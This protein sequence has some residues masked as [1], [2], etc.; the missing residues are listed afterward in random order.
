V[1]YLT[2]RCI[3]PASDLKI[4]DWLRDTVSIVPIAFPIIVDTGTLT[5]LLYIRA[6]FHDVEN[7]IVAIL[8][9]LVFVYLVLRYVHWIEKI[10]G[11]WGMN[12]IRKVFG[13][14]LLAIAIKLFRTNAGI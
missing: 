2:V 10:L 7:I 11:K 3:F 4:Q 13:V 8:I 5:T 1:I 6:E 12:I 14:I 9:N